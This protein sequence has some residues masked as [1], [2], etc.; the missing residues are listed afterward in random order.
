MAS[1]GRLETSRKLFPRID[2]TSAR[3]PSKAKKT[4]DIIPRCGNDLTLLVAVVSGMVDFGRLLRD[5]NV[6]AIAR[7]QWADVPLHTVIGSHSIPA[8][9]PDITIGFNLSDDMLT[10]APAI[11]H[12]KP[13]S[14]PAMDN[15]RI[16]LPVFTLEAKETRQASLY[17]HISNLHNGATMLRNI[18]GLHSVATSEHDCRQGLRTHNIDH[19]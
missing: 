7:G 2:L 6:G 8:A 1:T 5:D 4:V 19:R 3:I 16:L 14:C 18:R 12:L 11:E 15:P 9:C 10:F 13:F 17:S